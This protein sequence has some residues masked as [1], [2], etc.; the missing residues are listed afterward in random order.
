MTHLGRARL[1]WRFNGVSI[2]FERKATDAAAAAAAKTLT[3]EFISFQ[4]G[5]VL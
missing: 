3:N 4:F 1:N 5:Y 2:A